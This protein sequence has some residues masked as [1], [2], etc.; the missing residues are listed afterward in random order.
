MGPS[1]PLFADF[2]APLSLSLLS[3]LS[4]F[5]GTSEGSATASIPCSGAPFSSP[6]RSA[7]LGE[8]LSPQTFTIR[9]LLP[10]SSVTCA[11][12]RS[13]SRSRYPGSSI[14]FLP[15][16]STRNAPE[17]PAHSVIA[18]GVLVPAFAR[19]NVV[20]YAQISSRGRIIAP[21]STHPYAAGSG[22]TRHFTER[23]FPL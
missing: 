11:A 4:V 1:A 17:A 13:M 19:T 2:V 9:R 20:A 8:S 18:R 3:L 16:Q 6:M 21:K 10:G 12:N 14:V 7:S 15:F 5:T 23:S 22:G